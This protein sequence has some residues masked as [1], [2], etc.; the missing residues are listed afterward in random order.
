MLL[1]VSTDELIELIVSLRE[2]RVTAALVFKNWMQRG[3]QPL[4]KRKHF[5]FQYEGT[6]DESRLS[7]E[8]TDSATT[9]RVI[10]SIFP[11]Q[12]SVPY[13]PTVFHASNPPSQV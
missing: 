12:L 7:A 8:A 13:V 11:D 3:I 1:E 4:Q 6:Q 5:G 10:Q 9:L 2:K